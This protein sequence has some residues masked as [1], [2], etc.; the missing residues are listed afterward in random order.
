MFDDFSAWA[1]LVLFTTTSVKSLSMLQKQTKKS[2][3]T[4]KHN[5][6]KQA[7]GNWQHK[8]VPSCI[9]LN[10][11]SVEDTLPEQITVSPLTLR[12]EYEGI[13]YLSQQRANWHG[14]G[15][16]HFVAL[17]CTVRSSESLWLRGSRLSSVCH[18]CHV[19]SL[20]PVYEKYWNKHDLYD[21]SH[22]SEYQHCKSLIMMSRM[23]GHR[24]TWQHD[25]LCLPLPSTV[26]W[27]TEQKL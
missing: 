5:P 25:R 14:K 23:L 27:D 22:G 2:N 10:L 21:F 13:W 16:Q 6:L 17:H 3:L 12:P 8:I 4:Q 20:H 15:Q 24:V 11:T 19:G 7:S 26:H 9:Q 18:S 1:L